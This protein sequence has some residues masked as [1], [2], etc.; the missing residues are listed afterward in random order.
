MKPVLL[1]ASQKCDQCLC[2]RNRIVTG[3]RAA[4][5]V[6]ECREND[7]HFICHKADGEI[8]HCRGVH[9]VMGG[10]AAYRMAVAFDIEVREVVLSQKT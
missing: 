6:R 8:I 9:D 1:L 7:N 4:A 3:E 10:S 2:T 5:I